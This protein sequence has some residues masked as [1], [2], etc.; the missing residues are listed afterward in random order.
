MKKMQ[1]ALFVTLEPKQVQRV[2]SAM[3]R[4]ADL[5]QEKVGAVHRAFL[6]RYSK[7]HKYWYGQRRL[8]A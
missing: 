2:G 3:A 4:A 1:L 5:S 7:V 6:R 8:Y